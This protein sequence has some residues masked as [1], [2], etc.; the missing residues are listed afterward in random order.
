MTTVFKIKTFDVQIDD[1]DADL[2]AIKWY[3]NREGGVSYVR[4]RERHKQNAKLHRVIMERVLGRPLGKSE[5]V[6][7]KDANPFNNT[8]SNLRIA[9]KA[10]NAANS[11]VY[12]TSKSGVKGVY[13]TSGGRYGARIKYNGKDIHLGK[14]DKI[15]DAQSA[16]LK[17][18]K[19][20]FGEFAR[21]E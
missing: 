4:S 16:Y 18:A 7:H 6:D 12:S 3:V 5:I 19:Y 9:T 20:Y 15:E 8:R 21:G 17:A 2:M 11:H 10:Q 14:F 1:I 13:K